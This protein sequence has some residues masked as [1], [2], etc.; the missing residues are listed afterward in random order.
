MNPAGLVEEVIAID[1]FHLGAGQQMALR[2]SSGSGKTT[3]L[4]LIAGLLKPDQGRIELHEQDMA[5]MSEPAR[6][7]FRA[8]YIGYIFQTFNLLQGFTVYEN[9]L[10]GTAF[11]S[12]PNP[13][14]VVE[15]L[16]KLGL[17]DRRDHYPRQLSAGQQQRVAA[18]RALANRPS[19]V[20]ADEP[21]GN[22]DPHHA[23]IALK[24]IR[25]TCAEYNAA[26]LLVTHDR[27]T[28]ESFDSVLDLSDIN[29]SG[30]RAG[31]EGA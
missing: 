5:A 13:Q 21:T 11:G 31:K 29:R 3:F 19:L 14:R 9:I 28:W 30:V 25:D 7:R 10:L 20:L 26:L 4:H 18:A 2:G 17:K 8:R 6:D 24:L 16:D 27:S 23:G 15:L 22:L 12:G 1:H